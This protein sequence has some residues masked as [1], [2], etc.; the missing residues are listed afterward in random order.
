MLPRPTDSAAKQP[1][2]RKKVTTGG[3][4]R[5]SRGH[6]R[7]CSPPK[8]EPPPSCFATYS[9]NRPRDTADVK[10]R[11]AAID[12]KF[13]ER[14]RAHLPRERLCAVAPVYLTAS[15]P[16]TSKFCNLP[17]QPYLKPA[18]TKQLILNFSIVLA[19]HIE[20]ILIVFSKN[21]F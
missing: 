6:S 3:A 17:P 12:H 4:L 5:Q 1:D 11:S 20:Q 14:G 15:K 7:P 16:H 13:P 2:S 21:V 10:R 18:F 9:P 19:L 8:Q